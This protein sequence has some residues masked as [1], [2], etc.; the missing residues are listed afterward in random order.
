MEACAGVLWWAEGLAWW[1][2]AG[3]V[4]GAGV[5]DGGG[6]KGGPTECAIHVEG[7]ELFF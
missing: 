7:V 3:R 2:S 6:Q 4:L 1:G 5:V